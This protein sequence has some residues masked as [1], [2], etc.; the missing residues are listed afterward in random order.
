MYYVF[1]LVKHRPAYE[2]RIRDWSSD[3]CSS[4]L[5]RRPM[6]RG[7]L[8]DGPDA[9]P[10]LALGDGPDRLADRRR[11]VAVVVVDRDAARLSL[12][13]ET[14]AHAREARQARKCVL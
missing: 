5:G 1:F 12:P 7:R 11:M 3:V 9:T 6:V 2:R 8:V 10:G 13:L 4:E 14:A